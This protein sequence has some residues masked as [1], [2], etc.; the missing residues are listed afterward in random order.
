VSRVCSR[1]LPICIQIPI[2]LQYK[3]N[4]EQLI[5]PFKTVQETPTLRTGF[6]LQAPG[7]VN[8]AEISDDVFNMMISFFFVQQQQK[9]KHYFKP[10]KHLS[11][12][13]L[14]TIFLFVLMGDSALFLPPQKNFSFHSSPFS[15]RSLAPHIV[16]NQRFPLYHVRSFFSAHVVVG[17]MAM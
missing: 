6:P 2:D 3:A 10:L 11:F 1:T 8:K 14:K 9:R 16:N 7:A 15:L 12:S 13:A 17:R 5:K 4:F